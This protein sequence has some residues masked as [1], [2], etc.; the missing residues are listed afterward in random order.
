MGSGTSATKNEKEQ[1]PS[2]CK[3]IAA[4]G[5]VS[6]QSLET[7][8]NEVVACHA[9]ESAD[10]AQSDGEKRR[11]QKPIENNT[12][13]P[14]LAEDKAMKS[15]V[16]LPSKTFHRRE[17]KAPAIAFSDPGKGRAFFHE[18]LAS[19]MCESYFSLAEHFQTQSHYA[20]CGISSLCMALNTMLI[21]PG[22]VYS[23]P[24]R[25]FDDSML[26]CCRELAVV[27]KKGI[28]MSEL[29]CLAKCNGA[30][31]ELVYASEI[32]FDKFKSDVHLACSESNKQARPVMVVSYS[33]R[34][35][36]QTGS[37]HFSP[38]GAYAPQSEMVLI[39]DVARFK[40]PPHWVPLH[41]LWTAM[42]T[43]DSET[44]RSRG[45]LLLRKNNGIPQRD[46]S[47]HSTI[48]SMVNDTSEP[49]KVFCEI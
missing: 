40:Y 34:E 22:R 49:K 38:I 26:D 16:K 21:D 23:G 10:I 35:V 11:P 7:S 8:V 37:G 25:W 41:A 6:S 45:Y 48:L 18:A 31:C 39:M 29:A 46:C 32:S 19:G 24:W 33:R 30:L 13:V 47:H 2:N 43:T 1:K 9:G 14:I 5:L 3:N 44:S 42:L 17:L 15:F 27:Q 28:A 4:D 20:Y 12:V 36:N